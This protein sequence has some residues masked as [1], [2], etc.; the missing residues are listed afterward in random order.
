MCR[1]QALLKKVVEVKPKRQ[2][3]STSSSP[4]SSPPKSSNR[5][6][7]E[8]KVHRDKEKAE[9]NTVL[10]KLDRPE[11]QP[12]ADRNDGKATESN[13][14]GQNLLKGLLGLAYES[15]DEED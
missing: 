15:S 3:V 4:S 5:V 7:T 10:I 2:K 9:A 11:E 8:A 14:Q 6:P 12:G 13:G 1:Q